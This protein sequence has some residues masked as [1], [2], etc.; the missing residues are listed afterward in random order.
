[1]TIL[2]SVPA[3]LGRFLWLV[4]P[5]QWTSERELAVERSLRQLLKHYPAISKVD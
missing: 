2:S 3:S 5:K 1:M 4:S